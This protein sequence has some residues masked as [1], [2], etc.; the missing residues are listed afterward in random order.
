MCQALLHI[1]SCSRQRLRPLKYL[2]T[3]YVDM[4]LSSEMFNNNNIERN[5]ITKFGSH[6]SLDKDRK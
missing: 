5:W 3:Q 1:L 4:L 6:F 2:K